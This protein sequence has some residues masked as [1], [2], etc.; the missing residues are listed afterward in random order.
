MG[1]SGNKYFSATLHPWACLVFVL[2]L[3]A[4]YEG[5]VV[6]LSAAQPEALRN[7]A[8]TWLRWAL[9]AF[10]LTQLY[11]APAILAVFLM[12]WGW[13]RS[14]DRPNELTSLWIGM[15]MESVAYAV[16]LWGIS[17]GLGP[18]LDHLGIRLAYPSEI[19]PAFQQIITFLGAGIY[20]E[21]LFRLIL[22][23]GL[24]WLLGTAEVPRRTALI[25]AGVTS[26]VIFSSAH[27][28]GPY[29]EPFNGYYFFFRTVAGLYFTVVYQMRGF[30]IA[31]GA[32]AFYDVLV[33]VL[34]PSA[35]PEP[36]GG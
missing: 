5:G 6:W 3:L 30:G 2:P 11:W 1:L 13:L 35:L 27:H 26:A 15:T 7:G 17:R 23:S 21:V 18:L 8:D 36:G 34:V 20:E 22:F 19:E 16:G 33:G 14:S 31:V 29:G 10:G 24:V 4:L 32:H 9:D 25:A 28:A 12:A